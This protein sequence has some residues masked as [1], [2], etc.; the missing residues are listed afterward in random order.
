MFRGY[1]LRQDTGVVFEEMKPQIVFPKIGIVASDERGDPSYR[2]G[3]PNNEI[4]LSGKSS[5]L[6][7]RVQ[8]QA[9]SFEVEV[10]AFPR[11]VL[12]EDVGCIRIRSESF[13]NP[14]LEG[15]YGGRSTFVV[16]NT[17]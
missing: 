13:G 16:R 17:R 7:A 11:I 1:F 6:K 5:G 3:L 2:S 8:V 14:Q 4:R 12:L 9:G 15:Q 10:G